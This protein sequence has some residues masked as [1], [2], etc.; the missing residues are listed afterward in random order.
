[1]D[2]QMT[3][4]EPEDFTNAEATR[5]SITI[6][7]TE[8]PGINNLTENGIIFQVDLKGA[9]YKDVLAALKTIKSEIRK[10]RFLALI[11]GLLKQ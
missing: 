11:R 8:G 1:M 7:F 10:R 6:K 2:Y 9:P 5:G 3:F 4:Q